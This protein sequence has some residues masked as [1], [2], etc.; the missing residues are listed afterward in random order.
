MNNKRAMSIC[1]YCIVFLAQCRHTNIACIN[2]LSREPFRRAQQCLRGTHDRAGR[3]GT[4]FFSFR[5]FTFFLRWSINDLASSHHRTGSRQFL[6]L[7]RATL[8]ARAMPL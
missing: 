2:T 3:R 6:R 7:A 4:A 1:S 5:A 8:S